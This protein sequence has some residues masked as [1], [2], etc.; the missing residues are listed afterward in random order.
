MTFH[1]LE[2][3]SSRSAESK[4]VKL[5][6]IPVK[7]AHAQARPG[8]HGGLLETAGPGLSLDDA[9]GHVPQR[10]VPQF[11]SFVKG[12]A[13]FSGAWEGQCCSCVVTWITF[14]QQSTEYRSQLRP[15]TGH[16][17]MFLNPGLT[18]GAGLALCGTGLHHS[19]FFSSSLLCLGFS[20]S[21]N[22]DHSC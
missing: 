14:L 8:R 3:P 2:M 7:C 20:A 18:D 4:S 5:S 12:Q 21:S 9:I 16:L 10:A 22:D 17:C 11:P 1:S 6:E 13:Q 19:S 15:T